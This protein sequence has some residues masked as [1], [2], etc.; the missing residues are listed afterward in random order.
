MP[1]TLM[2]PLEFDAVILW[3]FV[4]LPVGTWTSRYSQP[5]L[6]DDELP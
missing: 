6:P 5:L 1:L 4:A 3:G 2:S